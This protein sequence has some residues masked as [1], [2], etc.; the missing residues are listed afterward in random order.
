MRPKGA[1]VYF[2][3]FLLLAVFYYFYEHKGGQKR[4][5]QEELEK[6]ALVFSLDSVQGFRVVTR[7]DRTAPADTVALS[8]DERGRWR[9]TFPIA[10]EADSQAVEDLLS[11]ASDASRHRVVE[12]SAA[13]L[14][15]FGLDEPQLVL[16]LTTGS[17]PPRTLQL[18][19]G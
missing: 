9:L 4:E 19:L 8:R 7:P 5:Q 13:D 1:L 6:K 16:E 15:I 17:E 2:T 18:M 10:A 14:A 12:D 3:V 11:S